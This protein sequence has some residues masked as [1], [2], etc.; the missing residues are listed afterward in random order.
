[1]SRFS[2]T[3]P[4]FF[5]Q[6][7]FLRSDR[8]EKCVFFYF[9]KYLV[10]TVLHSSR[11]SLKLLILKVFFFLFTFNP[12]IFLPLQSVSRVA[13]NEVFQFSYI[14]KYSDWSKKIKGNNLIPIFLQFQYSLGKFHTFEFC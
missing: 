13:I 1:M 2:N 4:I 7:D 5:Q 10:E 8:F 6:F 3:I 14:I 12:Y 9:Y 11:C